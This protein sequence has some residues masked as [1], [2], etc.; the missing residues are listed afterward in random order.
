M[1][2]DR[3][4]A[5]PMLRIDDSRRSPNSGRQFGPDRFVADSQGAATLARL[6]L[7]ARPASVLMTS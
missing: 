5:T 6:V 7:D 3:T 4:T 1:R 2:Q